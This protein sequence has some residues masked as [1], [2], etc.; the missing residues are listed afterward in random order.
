MGMTRS[1]VD[2]LGLLAAAKDEM[3][4]IALADGLGG[5]RRSSAYRAVNEL[6]R[7]GMVSARWDTDGPNAR[8]LFK[9]TALGEQALEVERGRQAA[10]GAAM[11][12]KG[13]RT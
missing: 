6:Q 12:L 1:Q 10:R 4:G 11:R 9:I 7:D 8:R 2:V 3:P 13:A 5:V